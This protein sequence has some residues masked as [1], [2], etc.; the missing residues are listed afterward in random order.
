MIVYVGEVAKVIVGG[1]IKVLIKTQESHTCKT[2]KPPVKKEP[3]LVH[4]PCQ[5]C[6]TGILRF[7]GVINLVDV[8]KNN[9]ARTS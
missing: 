3:L 4:W 2:V 5:L 9:I 6:K 1:L 8:D 7:K